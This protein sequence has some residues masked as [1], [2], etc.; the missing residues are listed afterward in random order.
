MA[1]AVIVIAVAGLVYVYPTL[2]LLPRTASQSANLPSVTKQGLLVSF[3]FVT[4]SI[5]WALDVAVAPTGPGQFWVFRT[6]DRAMHWRE[7]LTGET[8]GLGSLSVQFFDTTNGLIAVPGGQ[9]DFAYR[10]SD[11]GAHWHPIG[12]PTRFGALAFSDPRNGWLSV[13]T[14]SSGGHSVN[15]YGTGDG[16]NTWQRLPDPPTDATT[17]VAFRRPSEGW[18]GSKGDPLPHVYTTSDAGRSWSRHNLPLPATGVPPGA[19]TS[20]YL[21][22]GIGAIA[23]LDTGSGPSFPLTSFDGGVSWNYVAPSASGESFGDTIGFQDAFHWCVIDGN[24]LYRSS[25]AGLTWLP[26][27]NKLPAGLYFCQF[28]DS[29]HGWGLVA[30]PG[31]GKGLASTEDGGLHWTRAGVPQP[32]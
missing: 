28:L 20:I 24:T 21:L 10:T 11:G 31:R 25:D 9:V 30:D 27:S 16:G 4:P 5:G 6:T 7:Q 8:T 12:L 18:M 22:P 32:A 23:F 2:L 15:L 26:I 1:L 13:G 17:T 19:I 29:K 3:D 14:A